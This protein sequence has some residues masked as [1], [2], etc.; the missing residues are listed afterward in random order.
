ML[1]AWPKAAGIAEG[2]DA[3]LKAAGIAE[4]AAR[5]RRGGRG[6]RLAAQNK[7]TLKEGP[8]SKNKSKKSKKSNKP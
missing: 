5:E 4:G 6:S 3:W 1:D 2:A 8:E 7:P